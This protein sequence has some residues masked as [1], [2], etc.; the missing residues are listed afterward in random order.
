VAPEKRCVVKTGTKRWTKA[1]CLE[2]LEQAQV[3]LQASNRELRVRD[4]VELSTGREDLPSHPVLNE[5]A[6][7]EGL[8]LGK[9]FQEVRGK[10]GE[11][12]PR[13]KWDE[14]SCRMA[15]QALVDELAPTELTPKLFRQLT[16]QRDSLPSFNTVHKLA[17]ARGQTAGQFL[18]EVFRGTEGLASAGGLPCQRDSDAKPARRSDVIDKEEPDR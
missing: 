5:F 12:V 9:W 14:R 1:L 17:K 13:A 10:G 2:A 18:T 8:T 3:E 4:Y 16:P 6:A 11:P 15:L 7:Q